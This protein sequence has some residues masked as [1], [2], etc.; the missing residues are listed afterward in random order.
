[1]QANI[2]CGNDPHSPEASLAATRCGRSK[3]KKKSA[4]DDELDAKLDK[5]L[6]EPY[7]PGGSAG[8][9]GKEK[10][11][12]GAPSS[13]LFGFDDDFGLDS[14]L[15]RLQ[16][17]VGIMADMSELE[18]RVNAAGDDAPGTALRYNVLSVR[19]RSQRKSVYRVALGWS[20]NWAMLLCLLGLF[21]L[22]VCEFNARGA[23]EDA[24]MMHRELV[25]AWTWSVH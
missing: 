23:M 6:A 7:K 10:D 5:M 8:R 22:Y 4:A 13:S 2:E 21:L 11:A 9:K 1:M 20:L 3:R 25:L 15:Q 24:Y 17:A 18:Q 12:A 14:D 16:G 19:T